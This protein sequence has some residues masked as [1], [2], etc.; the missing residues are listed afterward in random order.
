MY[1]EEFHAS[2]WRRLDISGE[3]EMGRAHHVIFL[4]TREEWSRRPEWARD[5]RDEIIRRIKSVFRIPDYEYRGE[6]VLTEEDK[7]YLIAISGGLSDQPCAWAG[8]TER[9]LNG[10][11]ICV[12][13][14]YKDEMQ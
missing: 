6:A 14:R 7:P 4:G 8:C 2:K 1:Y 12:S 9:A 5:R 10:M 11:R 3:L 13:H